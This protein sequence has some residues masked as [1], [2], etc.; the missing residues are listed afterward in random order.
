MLFG[1][2]KQCMMGVAFLPGHCST[3]LCVEC[4]GALHPS[5]SQAYESNQDPK[6]AS[7]YTSSVLQVWPVKA[8]ID[9]FFHFHVAQGLDYIARN[10]SKLGY[11]SIFD[12]WTSPCLMT[13]Q[14]TWGGGDCSYPN[15]D[16]YQE[17]PRVCDIYIC[18]VVHLPLSK[19]WVNNLGLLLIT[20][21]WMEK[22]VAW[23]ILKI[24]MLQTTNQTC[25]HLESSCT[26]LFRLFLFT[27]ILSPFW[28]QTK[29]KSGHLKNS[30]VNSN[31]TTESFSVLPGNPAQQM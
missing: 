8:G 13:R 6:L 17:Y 4:L 2:V 3:C 25:I 31:R 18:L 27:C 9:H 30:Q 14:D 23:N 10:G 5:F 26:L 29:S 21:N 11:L 22:K 16:I 7:E 28:N 1:S 24:Q 12:D 19:T 20:P 15:A